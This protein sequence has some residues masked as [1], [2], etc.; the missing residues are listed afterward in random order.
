MVRRAVHE[1]MGPKRPMEQY[2]LELPPAIRTYVE[3]EAAR[4]G[5]TEAQ[6][7]VDAIAWFA[8]C[9]RE[10]LTGNVLYVQA[11]PHSTTELELEAGI[12]TPIEVEHL[13]AAPS[14]LLTHSS[15]E[16]STEEL[17][18]PHLRLLQPPGGSTTEA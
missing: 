5:L 11:T 2:D 3:F 7:I 16:G 8:L 15:P 6:V 9:R 12:L 1:K 13:S 18:R 17:G 4:A 10:T 14:F